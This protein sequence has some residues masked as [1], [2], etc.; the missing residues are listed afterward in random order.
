MPPPHGS[1][2]TSREAA[3]VRASAAAKTDA[4]APPRPP[5]T[6]I[7]RPSP[8]T[9]AGLFRGLGK[10]ADQHGAPAPGS[11]H[12]CWA[13]TA[14]AACQVDS[15][16]SPPHTRISPVAA[17]HTRAQRRAAGSSSTTADAVDHVFAGRH[18]V[19][20]GP[21]GSPP[22]PPPG[23][24]RRGARRRRAWSARCWTSLAHHDA[25]RSRPTGVGART[26][27]EPGCGDECRSSLT[28]FAVEIVEPDS[29][30]AVD[31]SPTKQTIG[32]SQGAVRLRQ[33]SRGPRV[34]DRNRRER[35]ELATS[36]QLA[37][38]GEQ[39]TPEKGTTPARGGGGGGRRVSAPGGRADAHP[40]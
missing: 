33:S 8:S 34:I 22:R 27:D 25:C 11:A 9:S 19:R 3:A 29:V 28:G 36:E 2:S 14:I 35:A 31:N 5:T 40:A 30:G 15:Q 7:T 21:P 38:L 4:P 13:P 24:R 6:A 10:V 18:C 16:G 12:T 32:T 23:R 1:R 37:E 39:M 20:R 17:R 26:V